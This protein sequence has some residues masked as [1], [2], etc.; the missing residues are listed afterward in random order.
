MPSM[1][2]GDRELLARLV[3][4]CALRA[5]KRSPHGGEQREA[6]GA[7]AGLAPSETAGAAV[8]AGAATSVASDPVPRRI[9]PT[10]QAASGG[11]Q[12]EPATPHHVAMNWARPLKRVFE[13]HIEACARCGGKL[14]IVASIEEPLVIAK[15]LS[16]LE[17]TAP[18]PYQPELPLG[19]RAPPEQGW[20]L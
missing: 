18:N 19:A 11:E 7:F 1:Q 6:S 16:H 8:G 9:G 20:L 13:V 17:K 3:A 5:D 14:S 15:I 12:N 2:R 4:A 10:Q